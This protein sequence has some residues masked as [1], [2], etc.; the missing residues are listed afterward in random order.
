MFGIMWG[1]FF[2]SW[3]LLFYFFVDEISEVR[4]FIW[5]FHKQ[6]SVKIISAKWID[7]LFEKIIIK[8]Q[9]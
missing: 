7:E 1:F 4:K 9:M 8:C 2:K 5:E 3:S 6:E